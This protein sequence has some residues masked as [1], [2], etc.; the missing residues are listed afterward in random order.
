MVFWVV[1]ACGLVDGYRFGGTYRLHP[2]D[3]VSQDRKVRRLY[4]RRMAKGNERKKDG[5]GGRLNLPLP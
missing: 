4:S 1:T 5:E 3:E 2:Q